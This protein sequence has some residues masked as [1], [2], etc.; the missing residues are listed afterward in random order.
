MTLKI[1][2]HQV[3]VGQIRR[4][5][6]RNVRPRPDQR[7]VALDHV[8][9][10][11]NFVEA[12]LAQNSPHRRHARVA[13]DRLP[14]AAHVAR[15]DAHGAELVDLEAAVPIAVAVLIEQHRARRRRLYRDCNCDQERGEKQQR[16]ACCG[17]VEDALCDRRRRLGPRDTAR[18]PAASIRTMRTAAGKLD[19]TDRY[20]GSLSSNRRD[21]VPIEVGCHD[22]GHDSPLCWNRTVAGHVELLG[23]AHD[24]FA[25]A[26]VSTS[27]VAKTFQNLERNLARK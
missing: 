21:V 4:Q 5:H 22:R 11:R 24:D 26:N 23:T 1:I 6:S 18:T 14:Y 10:L 19:R 17:D 27:E 15:I 20:L 16:D 3:F 8:E 2:W 13:L 9:Q 7:H 12:G 25:A